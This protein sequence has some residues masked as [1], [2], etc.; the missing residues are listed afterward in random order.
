M[1]SVAVAVDIGGTKVEAALVDADGRVV[2]GSRHRRPTG[3]ESSAEQLWASVEQAVSAAVAAR[4]DRGLAGLGL[5]SAGPVD[6]PA[7]TAS[8]LNL[9]AFR[10]F[11]LRDRVAELVPGLPVVFAMDGVAIALAE[12]W[13]GAARGA[14]TAMGMIVS[15]GIGGGIVLHG[16]PYGGPSGN[17]GHVGHIEVG[18]F[19]DVPCVCGGHSCMEAIASGPN[20][21]AWARTQGFAGSTG[22]ELAVAHAAGDPVAVAAVR[23]AGTAIGRGIASACALLDLEVVAIGGGFARVSPAL[24]DAIADAIAERTL[25]DYVRR[26]RVVPSGLGADGPLV[27]AAA[28]VLRP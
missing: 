16:R 7:G 17:A 26:V 27:G 13:V 21:V 5:A 11:P 8:F 15:T 9:P 22:E 4:G 2:P 1:E 6:V 3:R 25:L 20:T 18:G 28:L 12:H 14:D 19:G 10:G 24:F 23:R